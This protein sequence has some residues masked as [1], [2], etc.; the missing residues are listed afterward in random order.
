MYV[1]IYTVL[2]LDLGRRG[3]WVWHTVFHKITDLFFK[4]PY[5]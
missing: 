3:S 2:K 1:C 5:T 4:T